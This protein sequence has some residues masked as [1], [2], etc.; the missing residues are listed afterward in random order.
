MLFLYNAHWSS[1]GPKL[2]S[3]FYKNTID[4]FIENQA[5]FLILDC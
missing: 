5:K 1:V 2:Y 3:G 4:L